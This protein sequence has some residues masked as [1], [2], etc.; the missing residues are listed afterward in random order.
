M[1]KKKEKE[2]AH[3]TNPPSLPNSSCSGQNF[4]RWE[5]SEYGKLHIPT[6]P[7]TVRC[8]LSHH[9]HPKKKL[10]I[11]RASLPPPSYLPFHASP[12]PVD[13]FSHDYYLRTTHTYKSAIYLVDS[14]DSFPLSRTIPQEIQRS[15]ESLLFFFF[16]YVCILFMR[17][18]EKKRCE[19][20]LGRRRYGKQQSNSKTPCVCFFWFWGDEI[21]RNIHYTRTIL[22]TVKFTPD[23]YKI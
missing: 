14:T 18:R 8:L 15:N 17:G 22:K 5:T 1:S 20:A 19:A 16:G 11:W 21:E 12:T 3:Q 13:R 4:E 9:P 10:K 2:R 6:Y 23:I 7:F